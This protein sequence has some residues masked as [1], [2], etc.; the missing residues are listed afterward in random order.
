M[1][2]DMMNNAPSYLMEKWDKYIGFTPDVYD[3]DEIDERYIKYCDR[4]KVSYEEQL[5]I[6][7]ILSYV[8]KINDV[9]FRNVSDIIEIFENK[10]GSINFITDKPYNGLHP[11]LNSFID[12]WINVEKRQRDYK[13]LLLEI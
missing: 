5:E 2:S 11:K 8:Y 3:F 12:K 4:W 9:G 1:D 10:F 7:H 13:L 6:S